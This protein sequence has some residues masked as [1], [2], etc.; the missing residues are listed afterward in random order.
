AYP[1]LLD[2]IRRRREYP[3]SYQRVVVVTDSITVNA[4]WYRCHADFF[5]LPNEE[6]AMVLRGAGVSPESIRTFGFPVSPKFA[7]GKYASEPSG[8]SGWNVLFMINAARASAIELAR[9]LAALSG[10]RLTVTVGRDEQLR[11]AIDQIRRDSNRD[12]E[13]IGWC[14]ELPQ[15]LQSTH[16]LIS[17]AGG[18]TV[19]E[20]IAA[21]CPMVI[22]QVVPGQEEGNAQLI[23]QSGSGVIATTPERVVAEVQRILADDGRVW[24]EMATNIRRMS[25]PKASLEIARFLVSL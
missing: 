15:L 11:A 24:R 8:R 5:L 20:A 17:K 25:R 16:L 21:G 13:I 12:V 18:A 9:L 2:E 7:E 10:I 4:I 22:N 19:Q 23:A 1:H 6:S 14:N 3:D